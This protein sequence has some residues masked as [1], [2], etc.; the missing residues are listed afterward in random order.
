MLGGELTQGNFNS[1]EASQQ[2]ASETA[3]LSVLLMF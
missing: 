2:V 3:A 1:I